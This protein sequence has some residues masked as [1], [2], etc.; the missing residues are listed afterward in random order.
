M[1]DRTCVACGRMFQQYNGRPRT[2]CAECA[3]TRWYTPVAHET[4]PCQQCGVDF[5][6]H[7]QRRYCS[8]QCKARWVYLRKKARLDASPAR[9]TSCTECG[10][11]TGKKTARYCDDCR[12]PN[13]RRRSPLSRALAESDWPG[14]VQAMREKSVIA[15]GCWLWQG[16]KSSRGYG[17]I[18]MPDRAMWAAHRVAFHAS[19]GGQL[20]D[21]LPIHHKCATR[22]CVNPD[23]L[24]AVTQSENTAEMMARAAYVRRIDELERALSAVA[25]GHPLL[26]VIVY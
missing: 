1:P 21:G 7:A 20:L 16:A 2:R 23:H 18:R 6:G 9:C 8:S 5:T 19:S 14:V 13:Q 24:Q 3:P 4:K 12:P 25:P 22:A 10:S 26:S 11:V 15:D 17:Q